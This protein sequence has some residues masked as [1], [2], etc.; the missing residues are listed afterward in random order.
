M[1][2]TTGKSEE[3][4]K[5]SDLICMPS[6]KVCPTRRGGGGGGGVDDCV[7]MKEDITYWTKV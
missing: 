3:R 5:L 4:L 6:C 1:N 2:K 7:E